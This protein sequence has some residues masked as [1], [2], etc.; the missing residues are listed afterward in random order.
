MSHKTTVDAVAYV[1]NFNEGVFLSLAYG[2]NLH[3]VFSV[4]DVT[5]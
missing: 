5:I 3:F 1:E 2:G 4:C